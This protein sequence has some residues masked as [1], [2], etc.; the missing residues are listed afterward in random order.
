LLKNIFIGYSLPAADH[1][2]FSYLYNIFINSNII[3][4]I[5]IFYPNDKIILRQLLD[6]TGYL[7]VVELI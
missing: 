5:K 1:Y 3:Q 4:T 2:I 6:I 7:E